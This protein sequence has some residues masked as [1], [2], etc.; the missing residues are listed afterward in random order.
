[1]A[2]PS[3][4]AREWWDVLQ[5]KPDASLDVINAQYR[6]LA[7]DY[8]PDRGGNQAQMSELNIAY[9]KAKEARNQ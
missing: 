6:R 1:M 5:C 8:H 7:M 4:Q 9:R 2:L 3:S